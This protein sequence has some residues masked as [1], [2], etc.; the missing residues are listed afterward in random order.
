MRTAIQNRPFIA[1]GATALLGGAGYR[2]VKTEIRLAE[3]AKKKKVLVL[4]F[5]RMKIIEEKKSPI[6]SLANRFS[7][8]V[9]DND[10]ENSTRRMQM[11]GS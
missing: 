2:K 4:P 1:L 11:Q 9:E 5:H 3:D 8:A 10:G 7:G 6:S